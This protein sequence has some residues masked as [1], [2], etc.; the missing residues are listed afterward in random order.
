MGCY[1]RGRGRGRGQHVQARNNPSAPAFQVQDGPTG[2]QWGRELQRLLEPN[3]SIR[4]SEKGVV[5]SEVR[6]AHSMDTL[7][8]ADNVPSLG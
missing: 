5:G 7:A 6:L 8:Y 2:T 1:L 3:Q 4:N